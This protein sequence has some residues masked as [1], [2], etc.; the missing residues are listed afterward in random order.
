MPWGSER[1]GG[2]VPA[3]AD[4]GNYPDLKATAKFGDRQAQL[5]ARRIAFPS[6]AAPLNRRRSVSERFRRGDFT[7]EK[8]GRRQAHYIA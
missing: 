7:G 5:V 4:A 6:C 1:E 8:K 2:E 3:W